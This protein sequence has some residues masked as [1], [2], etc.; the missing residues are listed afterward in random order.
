MDRNKLR[1]CMGEI[2]VGY[3]RRFGELPFDTLQRLQKGGFSC[4]ESWN[5][6]NNN[7]QIVSRLLREEYERDIELM[8]KRLFDECPFCR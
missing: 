4:E 1:Q 8:E 5:I 6:V 3:L 7:V 2:D